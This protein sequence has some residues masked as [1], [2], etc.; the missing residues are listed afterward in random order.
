LDDAKM[1]V[2]LLFES[3]EKKLSLDFIGGEP[4][5]EPVLI[6]VVSEYAYRKAKQLNKE[7]KIRFTSNLTILNKRIQ[8]LI[9]KH[10]LMVDVSLDGV[11]ENHDSRR[12]TKQGKPTWEVVVKNIKRLN[13]ISNHLGIKYVYL[14]SDRDVKKNLDFITSLQP[15]DI[16][17]MEDINLIKRKNKVR[18][19]NNRL[20][21]AEW[22]IEYIKK[23]KAVP[24]LIEY[25]NILKTIYDREVLG[26]VV[27]HSC[28]SAAGQTFTVSPE[29]KVYGCGQFLYLD[30]NDFGKISKF[31]SVK[32]KMYAQCVEEYSLTNNECKKC[33]MRDYCIKCPCVYRNFVETGNSFKHTMEGCMMK[34]IY[35][36]CCKWIISQVE[37]EDRKILFSFLKKYLPP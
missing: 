23:N 33:R 19:R 28:C 20:K 5:L 22:F 31:D 27:P 12:R 25:C 10:N 11:K 7:L 18:L 34:L 6:D 21:I 4:F 26:K 14:F 35:F 17:V 13:K 24:H 36:D 29:G 3:K 16:I 30:K 15:N 9:K 1:A 2:D 32:F 37:G 8:D